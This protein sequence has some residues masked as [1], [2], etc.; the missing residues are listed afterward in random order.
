MSEPVSL[1]DRR[2]VEAAKQ[3]AIKVDPAAGGFF[4]QKL[5][6]AARL[7]SLSKNNP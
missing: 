2:S 7:A 1:E 3:I 5:E 6:E 4:R